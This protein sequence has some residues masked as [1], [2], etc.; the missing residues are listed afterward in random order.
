MTRLSL[1]GVLAELLKVN[2]VKKSLARNVSPV[3]VAA[4]EVRIPCISSYALMI[5]QCYFLRASNICVC[6]EHI[7]VPSRSSIDKMHMEL[8]VTLD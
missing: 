5:A 3:A 2:S 7:I 8:W 6:F 1:S 4:S